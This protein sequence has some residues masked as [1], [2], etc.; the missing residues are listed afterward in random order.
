MPIQH[1]V[2]A[3]NTSN[4]FELFPG[5]EPSSPKVE[6]PEPVGGMLFKHAVNLV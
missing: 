5:G 2:I 3:V 6:R 4:P 1:P